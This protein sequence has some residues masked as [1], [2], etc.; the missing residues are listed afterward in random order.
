MHN[1]KEQAQSTMGLV[2]SDEAL[3]TNLVGSNDTIYKYYHVSKAQV[4]MIEAHS[5]NPKYHRVLYW[6]HCDAYVKSK[7]FNSERSWRLCLTR[8]YKRWELKHSSPAPVPISDGYFLWW[9]TM[10]QTN[11]PATDRAPSA[12]P[13][14]DSIP[15]TQTTNTKSKVTT[16]VDLDLIE[17]VSPCSLLTNRNHPPCPLARSLS[18]ISSSCQYQFLSWVRGPFHRASIF[19]SLFGWPGGYSSVRSPIKRTRNIHILLL[20]NRSR[21]Y[22]NAYTSNSRQRIF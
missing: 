4:D 1:K 15:S 7:G 14:R 19:S 8:S 6:E 10:L 16:N 20:K 17:E 11:T 13:W 22:L 3:F 9:P 12:N 5:G 18:T 21:E 2:E